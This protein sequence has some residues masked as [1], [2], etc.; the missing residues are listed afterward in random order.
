VSSDGFTFFRFPATSNT[1]DTAQLDNAAIMDAR[2]INNLAGK[3]RASYGTPFDLQELAG[4]EGVD[5]N[6][7]TH[8]KIIDVV[9]SILPVYA[10]HDKNGKKINDPWSTPFASSGFDLDAVGVIHQAPPTAVQELVSAITFNVFPNPV[11]NKSKIQVMLKAPQ[12]LTIDVLD[13]MGRQV[14]IV[15]KEMPSQQTD[16]ISLEQLNLQNGIYVLRVNGEHA[17]TTKKIVF[18]ND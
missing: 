18:I 7:I 1:Q 9:G 13:L 10:T 6:N 4:T 16:L 2:K 14:G 15:A 12:I 8:V 5:I 3:Y 17:V 11:T